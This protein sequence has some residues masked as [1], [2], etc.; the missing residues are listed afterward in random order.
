VQNRHWIK[1]VQNNLLNG[2][3]FKLTTL[4]AFYVS[5]QKRKVYTQLLNCMKL[6]SA[7]VLKLAPACAATL[8]DVVRGC[9]RS[10]DMILSVNG[11]STDGATHDAVAHLLMERRA[12]LVE[13]K[14]VSWPGSPIWLLLLLLLES[15]AIVNRRVRHAQFS[16]T[17][18][19]VLQ[20]ITCGRT[21]ELTRG[22]LPQQAC[23]FVFL[24]VYHLASASGQCISSGRLAID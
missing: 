7:T 14:V 4:T 3:I 24:F 16:R 13:L 11:R 1:C 10:G 23:A 5:V 8:I 19:S 6:I 21:N 12:D 18:Y 2:R 22:S 20:S 15:V 17:A 9:Y